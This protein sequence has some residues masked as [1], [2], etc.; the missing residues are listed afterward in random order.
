M[1]RFDEL[2]N[3]NGFLTEQGKESAELLRGGLFAF[4][5][6]LAGEEELSWQQALIAKA[7]IINHPRLKSRACP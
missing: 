3:E 7:V 2:I 1:T 6:E 5:K 4:W